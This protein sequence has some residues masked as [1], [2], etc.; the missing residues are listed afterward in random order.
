M[1]C[2][3]RVCGLCA[4]CGA[5]VCSV[6]VWVWVYKLSRVWCGVSVF[7]YRR[8]C[9][10]DQNLKNLHTSHSQCEFTHISHGPKLRNTLHDY[11]AH[12]HDDFY[13]YCH[14]MLFFSKDLSFTP[15]KCKLFFF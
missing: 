4:A 7:E 2:A 5:C 3:R 14:G 11:N 9:R 10:V 8:K 13:H 15:Q 1:A 6:C 12:F